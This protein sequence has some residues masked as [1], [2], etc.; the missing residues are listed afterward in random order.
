ML[1]IRRLVVILQMCTL[2]Q[3]HGRVEDWRG[4]LAIDATGVGRIGEHLCKFLVKGILGL[5]IVLGVPRVVKQDYD[6]VIIVI[7]PSGSLE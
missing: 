2:D 6:L 5:L 4:S 1:A 3:W 7:D